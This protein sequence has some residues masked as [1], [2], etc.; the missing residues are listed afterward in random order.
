[1]KQLDFDQA[2]EVMKKGSRVRRNNGQI[3]EMENGRIKVSNVD[4]FLEDPK[5]DKF[6]ELVPE[7]DFHPTMGELSKG[8]LFFDE[9]NSSFEFFCKKRVSRSKLNSSLR[10]FVG[11][12]KVVGVFSAYDHHYKYYKYIGKYRYNLKP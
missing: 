9:S 12:V 1:M 10:R 5:Y 3:W 11:D 8:L 7:N 4:A 2:V 6:E